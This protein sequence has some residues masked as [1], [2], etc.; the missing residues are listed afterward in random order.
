MPA[1]PAPGSVPE[2]LAIWY[3]ERGRDLVRVTDSEEARL[4]DILPRA[5]CS[6]SRAGGGTS[7][8]KAAV[9]QLLNEEV[10]CVALDGG[11]ARRLPPDLT[12]DHVSAVRLIRGAGKGGSRRTVAGAVLR[13]TKEVVEELL[14]ACDPAVFKLGITCSPLLRWV[15]YERE[16]YV[17]MEL[18]FV[19]DDPGI[20]QMLEA[21]LI[22]VFADRP[23]CRNRAP[24]GEGPVGRGP[25]FNY[26]VTVPAGAGVGIA[27]RKRCIG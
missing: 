16:G 11:V 18:L 10:Q 22:G 24:G 4:N 13:Y 25:Y 23:G 5:L 17:R 21:A 7:E 8:A 19:S 1:P 14:F 15:S 20:V 2:R 6:A 27:Q 9:T 12:H 3:Q 26:L